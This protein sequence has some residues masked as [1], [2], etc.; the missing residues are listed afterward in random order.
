MKLISHTG[1]GKD[2]GYEYGECEGR[3]TNET[4]GGLGEGWLM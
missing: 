2:W 3:E 1:R 4:M